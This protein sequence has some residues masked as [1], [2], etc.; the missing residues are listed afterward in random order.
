MR[1]MRYK[2]QRVRKRKKRRMYQLVNNELRWIK[3]RT[4]LAVTR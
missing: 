4:S 1:E 3:T 2:R